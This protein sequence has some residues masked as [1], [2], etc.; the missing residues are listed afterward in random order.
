[1]RTIKKWFNLSGFPQTKKYFLLGLTITEVI[2]FVFSPI[3]FAYIT[4]LITMQ[5]ASSA[6]LWATIFF[7]LSLLG[8]L[9]KIIKDSFL[10]QA[11][12]YIQNSLLNMSSVSSILNKKEEDYITN[13]LYVLNSL[14]TFWF[15]VFSLII[16]SLLYSFTLFLFIALSLALC[17]G[18]LF[19]IYIINSK[20]KLSLK[21]NYYTN[22]FNSIINILWLIFTFLI[23]IWAIKLIDV[24]SITLT[25]FLLVT[26]F[27]SNHASKID[28]SLDIFIETKKLKDILSKLSTNKSLKNLMNKNKKSSQTNKNK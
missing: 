23:L 14:L 15:K 5:N 22:I 8:Y 4:S 12:L 13:F 6:L 21:Q 17:F 27:I 7:M 18:I 2:C 3:S 16:L 26:S 24:Q 25:A 9:V 11:T 19:L 28:F 1:M 20:Q 10:K